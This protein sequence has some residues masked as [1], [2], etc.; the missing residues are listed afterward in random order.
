M[1][2][3]SMRRGCNKGETLGFESFSV[4]EVPRSFVKKLVIVF[5]AIPRISSLA[6]LPIYRSRINEEERNVF[7]DGNSR[8]SVAIDELTGKSKG[9]HLISLLISP[10]DSEK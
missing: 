5:V 6:V 2:P 3:K 1:R 9:K 10:N 7:G 4:F 8:C